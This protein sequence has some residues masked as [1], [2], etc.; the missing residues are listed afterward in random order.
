MQSEAYFPV[1][2]MSYCQCSDVSDQEKE[3]YRIQN[4]LPPSLWPNNGVNE[5]DLEVVLMHR[6]S[7]SADGYSVTKGL[8]ALKNLGG[9]VWTKHRLKTKGALLFIFFQVPCKK[10]WEAQGKCEI[11]IKIFLQLR[12]NCKKRQDRGLS[13]KGK[14]PLCKQKTLPCKHY[15]KLFY[16][17]VTHEW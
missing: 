12:Q 13:Q 8:L 16:K 5:S 1:S 14:I 6:N 17:P 11:N 9:L 3:R 10:T 15:N 2:T 7:K 4:S